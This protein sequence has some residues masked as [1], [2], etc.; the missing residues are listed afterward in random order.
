[1]A[2]GANVACSPTAARTLSDMGLPRERII[3]VD[4]D[5]YSLNIGGIRATAFYSRHVRFDLRLMVSTLAGIGRRFRKI[6]PL[7]LKYPCGQVL[8][9]RI[10]A[11]GLTLLFFGSAG[12]TD[13]EL[14]TLA[15]RHT[16]VLLV[17]LQG[18]SRICDLA[19]NYVKH[20]RPGL[21][22]PHHHDD[23]FPPVSQ[24][25]DI[26]TFINGVPGANPD[27]RVMELHLNERRSLDKHG[28][29]LKIC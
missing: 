19:L 15:N 29:L 28:S 12:A 16:D 4:R 23:F 25:I 1:R 2:T 3:T 18:H 27:T 21:V 20:L 9:W 7:F 8:G 24:E 5:G 26:S 17:P 22:I 6:L 10:E 11:E 13:A 14:T